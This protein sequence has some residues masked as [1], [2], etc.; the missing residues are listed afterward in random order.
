[1]ASNYIGMGYD[2]GSANHGIAIVDLDALVPLMFS[3]MP[4]PVDD[5]TDRNYQRL[6]DCYADQTDLLIRRYGVRFLMAERFQTRGFGGDL[7]EKVSLMNGVAHEIARGHGCYVRLTPASHWKRDWNKAHP[8][9]T[10]KEIKADAKAGTPKIPSPLYDFA[11]Q[12]GIEPHELDA[13][14]M[15]VWGG[16]VD[17]ND[18][19]PIEWVLALARLITGPWTMKAPTFA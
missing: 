12:A 18:I 11:L 5:L 6:L 13:S 3:K 2:G 15:V 10:L 4:R 17:F 9:W 14:L 1:M 16:D 7:I 8:K 19:D